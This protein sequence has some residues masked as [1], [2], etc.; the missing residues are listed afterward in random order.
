MGL[1]AIVRPNTQMFGQR[2]GSFFRHT[3]QWQYVNEDGPERSTAGLFFVRGI[4]CFFLV[5]S[6]GMVV[7]GIRSL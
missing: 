4:G 3:N 2:S 6:V 5:I 1:L 7:S